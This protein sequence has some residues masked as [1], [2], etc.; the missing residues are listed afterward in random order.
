MTSPLPGPLWGLHSPL[1]RGD[2]ESGGG[3]SWGEE[4]RGQMARTAA[5][6]DLTGCGEAAGPDPK[7]ESCAPIFAQDSFRPV[8]SGHRRHSHWCS[9][10]PRGGAPR[11]T[12]SPSSSPLPWPTRAPRS[13]ARTVASAF[14][15]PPAT[16]RGRDAARGAVSGGSVGL[17]SPEPRGSGSGALAVPG[18]GALEPRLEFFPNVPA[19]GRG[20]GRG[21]GRRETP[22]EAVWPLPAGSGRQGG[23]GLRT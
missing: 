2:V 9:G 14:L 10:P 18:G 17:C 12:P 3:M 22:R 8:D 21:G 20:R 19:A 15:C 5:S 23:C 13:A 16:A 6:V 1:S 4:L 7:A 11:T